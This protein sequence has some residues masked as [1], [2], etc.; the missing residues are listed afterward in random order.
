MLIDSRH[1]SRCREG[2]ET[3]GYTHASDGC[4]LGNLMLGCSI[5]ERIWF[6]FCSYGVTSATFLNHA[7]TA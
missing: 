3:N 2:R 6:H 4:V 5:S 1:A 7:S